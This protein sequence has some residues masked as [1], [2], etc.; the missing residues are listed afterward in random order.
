MAQ[1]AE[2]SDAANA[3]PPQPPEGQPVGVGIPATVVRIGAMDVNGVTVV[4]VTV[5][6][7]DGPEL[8]IAAANGRVALVVQPMGS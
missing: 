2:P 8:A 3:Q 6:P 5:G 4:D 1:P 7:A